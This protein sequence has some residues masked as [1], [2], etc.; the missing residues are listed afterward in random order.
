ALGAGTAHA[1]TGGGTTPPPPTTPA[2]TPPTA[3]TTP[4]GQVFPVPGA[5]SFGDGFG[6]KRGHRGADILAACAEPVVAVSWARVVY[7]AKHARAGNYVVIRYKKLRQDYMYAHLT[8]RPVVRKKQKVAPGQLLGYVGDT[9]NASTCHLHFELWAGR[10][11]RGGRAVDPM[12][13]LLAWDSYS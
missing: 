7:I 8:G 1:Q 6:A 9:G 4:S 2:P 12:P 10:W 11:Y 5:H 3:P 13:H